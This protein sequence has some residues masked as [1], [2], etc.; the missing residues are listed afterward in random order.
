[1]ASAATSLKRLS[2]ELGGKSPAIVLEDAD[3][4]RAAHEIAQVI[5][6]LSGQMCTAIGRILIADAVWDRFVPKL[7]DRLANLSI[8]APDDHSA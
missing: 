1:M 8:G 2:L 7:R 3:L 4:D 5:V 6:P